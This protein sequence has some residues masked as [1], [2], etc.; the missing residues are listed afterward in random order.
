MPCGADSICS[1]VYVVGGVC[2][3]MLF[4]VLKISEAS[5]DMTQEWMTTQPKLR[6]WYA[7]PLGRALLSEV[8]REMDAM[9][10]KVFGYQ[11]LQLGQISPDVDLLEHSGLL[12]RMILDPNPHIGDV[13]VSGDA[14]QLPIAT[15]RVNLLLMLHT[16]EFCSDPHQL[17]READRVVTDDGHVLILG[18]SPYS[19][20]GIKRMVAGWRGQMPWVGNYYS[21]HRIHDWLSLL[22]FRVVDHRRFFTRLPYGNVPLL[23]TMAAFEQRAEWSRS[24]GAVHLI[25]ARKQTMPLSVDKVR[26]ARRPA[27]ILNGRFAT[28]QRTQQQRDMKRD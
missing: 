16:L 22:N 13:H 15:S 1:N 19:F 18:F 11:A 2:G 26:W 21:R 7:S 14:L 5:I 12:R 24:L 10:A 6:E 9:T 27:S 8:K 23:K 17:L 3:C 4:N 25:L 28:A 20:W